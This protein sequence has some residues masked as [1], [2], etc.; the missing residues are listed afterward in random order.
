MLIG[1]EG[2]EG[3]EEAGLRRG[4]ATATPE[5]RVQREDYALRG[6]ETSASQQGVELLILT[7]GSAL[8]VVGGQRL[9]LR[10]GMLLGFWGAQPHELVECA[11]HSAGYRLSI[12]LH[13]FNAWGLPALLHS[14]F[15]SGHTLLEAGAAQGF[16]SREE[17]ALW[18]QDWQQG[19]ELSRRAVL[20]EVEARFCRLAGRLSL[21]SSAP[22]TG[23]LGS[24]LGA[25]RQM[26]TVEKMVS[27]VSGNFADFISVADIAA[28]VGLSTAAAAR[29]FKKSSGMNL[30]AFLSRHR[31]AHARLLLL[32]QQLSVSEVARASGY[33]SVSRFYASYRTFYGSTP[34][35]SRKNLFL[36]PTNKGVNIA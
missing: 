14:A 16:A 19:G 12:P 22:R 26:Q 23:T 7:E 10:A 29:I 30:K 8:W 36:P 2:P 4:S 28:S 33:R 32:R 6:Q 34:L 9:K 35:S 17:L 24:P 18:A 20:L 3:I 13:I 5:F 31:L 1:T 21:S 15:L 27:Y 11:P 25:H